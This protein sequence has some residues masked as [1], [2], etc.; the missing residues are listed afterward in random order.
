VLYPDEH[1]QRYWICRC[2]CNTIKSVYERSLLKGYSTSCGCWRRE[3]AA[4]NNQTHGM[5]HLPEYYIYRSML[6]RCFNKNVKNF[7]LYGGRGI[8]VCRRWLGRNGFVNFLSDLSRRPSK[9]H[10]LDRRRVNSNYTPLN[11]RWATKKQ[12]ARNRRHVRALGSFTTEELR[13]ELDRR[14]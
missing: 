1:R 12:Q 5:S 3:S 14:K 2:K 8:T 4:I 7:Y 11:C 9:K 13:N 10:S 6:N